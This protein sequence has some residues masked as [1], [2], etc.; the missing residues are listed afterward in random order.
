MSRKIIPD[1]SCGNHGTGQREPDHRM[2]FSIVE[3]I[4]PYGYFRINQQPFK[5]L[6][7][8]L[9]NYVSVKLFTFHYKLFKMDFLITGFIVYAL[10]NR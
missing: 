5:L 1:D 8:A 7:R 6:Q 3:N 9:I 2:S 10:K 4:G